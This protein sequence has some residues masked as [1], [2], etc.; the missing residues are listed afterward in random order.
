MVERYKYFICD[1]IVSVYSQL[2]IQLLASVS[3]Y[4][5]SW[6]RIMRQGPFYPAVKLSCCPELH[7]VQL[8]IEVQGNMDGGITGADNG[9]LRLNLGFISGLHHLRFTVCEVAVVQGFLRVS[10]FPQLI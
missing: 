6:P 3:I 4:T 8:L 7:S 1:V 10:C 2:G 9:F 5:R